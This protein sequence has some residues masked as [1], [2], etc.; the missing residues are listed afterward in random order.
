V[1]E[2]EAILRSTIDGLPAR[3]REA[4]L[5]ARQHDFSYAAIAKMMGISVSTVEKHMARANSELR[6]ALAAWS[7]DVPFRS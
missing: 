3:P 6:E 4:F 7:R 5:L 2:L 1:K